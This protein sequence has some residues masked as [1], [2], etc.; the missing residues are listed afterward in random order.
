[1]PRTA[2]IIYGGKSTEHEIS[3]RSARN[4][5]NAIDKNQYNVLLIAIAKDEKWYLKSE[6]ELNGEEVV[7]ANDNGLSLVPGAEVDKLVFSK[8]QQSIGKVDVVFPIVH[9]TGGED[10]SLQGLLKVL[11]I[12]FVGPGVVGSAL[13]IDKE[14]AKRILTEAGIA[15]SKFLSYHKSQRDQISYEIAQAELGIPMYIK[16]PNLGSSVGISKVKTEEEFYAAIDLALQFDRKVLIESNIVGREIECA[17]MGNGDIKASP[18]GEVLTI[19]DNHTFYSYDAKYTDANGSVT[20]IPAE[21]DEKTQDRIR[22]IAIDT[23]K[24]LCCEGMARVDVFLNENGDIIVNE[25]NTIPGF[26]DIS[27]YPKLW[28]AA[29]I[30]YS[31]LINQLL[32]LALERHTDMNE[33]KTSV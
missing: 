16:P 6:K 14:V 2:A 17:V 31:E 3:I 33:M 21:M 27:M 11:N 13:C 32:E 1:M 9:G 20:V 5:A 25:V 26:T 19:G 30:S 28:G 15:N 18:V 22:K 4:I 7:L 23:Y 8:N 29:G 10:G 24:A 12:A